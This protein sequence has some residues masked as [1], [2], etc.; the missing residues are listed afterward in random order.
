MTSGTE[1]TF[2][3]RILVRK[4][5]QALPL[6]A[7]LAGHNDPEVRLR[8]IA[9]LAEIRS[10]QAMVLITGLTGDAAAA[11]SQPARLAARRLGIPAVPGASY[12]E[13]PVVLLQANMLGAFKVLLQGAELGKTGWRTAKTQDC[14]LI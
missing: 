13:L 8:V 10:D 4:G 11:V 6:L 5:E 3:Q 2:V 12:V 7:R 14:W 1:I 9:P